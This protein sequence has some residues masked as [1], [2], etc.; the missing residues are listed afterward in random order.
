MILILLQLTIY[1]S[2]I[3]AGAKLWPHLQGLELADLEFCN[4]DTID[5]LLGADIYAVILMEGL[6]KGHNL[7][8]IA[9]NTS[10]G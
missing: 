9:Q 5:I 4:K 1:A 7:E 6:R 10:F 2:E 8:P 3:A